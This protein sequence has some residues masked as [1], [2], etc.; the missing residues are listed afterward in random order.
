MYQFFGL[1]L[2]KITGMYAVEI[3]ETVEIARKEA[4]KM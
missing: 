4:H 2:R 3:A 1:S